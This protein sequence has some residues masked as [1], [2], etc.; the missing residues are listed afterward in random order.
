MRLRA[1][2]PLL[3]L[4]SAIA[5]GCVARASAPASATMQDDAALGQQL[6]ERRCTGCHSLDRNTEG[7]RLRTV[8][9][10][11][12]GSIAE[13]AYSDA[14]RSA[15]FTWDAASLDRWL[16]DTRS[17]VP[18]NDMDFRVERAEERAAIIAFLK[19]QAER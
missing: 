5:A 1:C 16:T 13:F 19:S 9:G 6:F 10:R 3:S 15:Q 8:Y 12:A 18:N 7:P 17:V 2:L 14:M 11:R 4:A